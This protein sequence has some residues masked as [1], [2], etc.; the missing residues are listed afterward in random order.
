M[1]I[2][3]LGTRP[4]N[5]VLERGAIGGAILNFWGTVFVTRTQL[6]F[7]FGLTCFGLKSEE[8]AIYYF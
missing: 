4:A 5:F 6:V 2:F 1:L 8:V 3:A 7:K